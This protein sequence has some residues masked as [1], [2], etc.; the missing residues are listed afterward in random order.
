M[1]KLLL[2]VLGL[3]LL[4]GWVWAKGIKIGVVDLQRAIVQSEKGKKAKSELDKEF[5]QKKREIDKKKAQLEELRNQLEKEAAILSEKAK[6]EKEK[7]YREKLKELQRMIQQ[8]K[9]E[10]V[11]REQELTNQIIKDLVS[12]IRDYGKKN[13]YTLILEKRGGVIYNDPSIDLTSEMIKI[14]DSKGKKK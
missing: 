1:R 10:L 13:G 7:E 11:K 6:K 3:F 14:Y 9:L 8:A 12:Q 5:Q 2:V 4:V